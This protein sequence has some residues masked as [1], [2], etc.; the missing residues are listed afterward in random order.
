MQLSPLWYSGPEILTALASVKFKSISS[1]QGDYLVPT[2]LLFSSLQ[3]QSFSPGM[4]FCQCCGFVCFFVCVSETT[5]LNW[6][7]T[8]ILSA[9]VSYM[10][11]VVF[12]FNCLKWDGKPVP[13]TPSQFEANYIRLQEIKLYICI[14]IMYYD[15]SFV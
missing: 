1:T 6:L 12:F 10:L 11:S 5:I 7:V 15:I 14:F 9:I 4:K 13:F 2:G 8:D 3:L